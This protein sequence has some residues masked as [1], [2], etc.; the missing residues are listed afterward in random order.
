MT[1]V[2]PRNEFVQTNRIKTVIRSAVTAC[3]SA[4]TARSVATPHPGAS[5]ESNAAMQGSNIYDG[6]SKKMIKEDH[7]L[8][9]TTKMSEIQACATFR[10]VKTFGDDLDRPSHAVHRR[11]GAHI[12]AAV[13]LFTCQRAQLQTLMAT[14][15][16]VIVVSHFGPGGLKRGRRILSSF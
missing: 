10:P 12:L 1:R 11:S 15:V 14:F 8:A 4:R 6:F 16:A 5:P 13:R 9:C 2:Y 7:Y 3:P